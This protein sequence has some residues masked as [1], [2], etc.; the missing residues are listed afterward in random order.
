M[1][2]VIKSIL[3]N[4]II[5]YI[6]SRY[7]TYGIQFVNSIIIAVALGPFYLGVWGF[8]NLVLQYIAQFNFGVNYSLNVLLAINKNDTVKAGSLLST[9]LFLYTFLCGFILLAALCL[10][11]F[12]IDIGSKYAFDKYLLFVLA[13]AILTHFNSLFVNYFRVYNKL[14]EIIFFQSITP[15][16]TLVILFLGK[17][18]SLL[19]LLLWVMLGGQLFSFL[20]FVINSRKHLSTPDY[21]YITVLLRKGFFLFIYNASFYMIMLSTRSVVSGFYTVEEFGF[22]TFSFTLANTIMLLFDSFNFLI[23]PKT[24][25]RFGH[26][27]DSN[28]I[29]R[30]L[31]LIRVNYIVSIHFVM[32]LFLLIFPFII[33]L[34]PQYNTIFKPFAL[35]AMTTVFYSNCFVFSSLLTAYGK[36]KMLSFMALLTLILNVVFALV[37]VLLVKAGYEYVILA[38]MLAYVIYNVLLSRYSY[39]VIHRPQSVGTFVKE[40]FPYRLFI[41]FVLCLMMIIF[42]AA[43]WTYYFL[44]LLFVV[45]NR[46]ELVNIKNV[47]GKILRDPSIINI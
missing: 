5:L 19:Y 34:F 1:S 20:L 23:Y 46:K 33:S 3:R 42:D 8:V 44:F 17:G 41:P 28:E 22:F 40:N 38:T 25:N 12:G 21:S 4:K 27:K 13:I 16:I 29:I 26:A 35:I 37:I 15:V 36:E 11:L 6:G 2:S 18:E 45:L 32:Y 47:L 14:G 30:I 7:V 31:D 24:I 9:S 39:H 10:H 43:Q